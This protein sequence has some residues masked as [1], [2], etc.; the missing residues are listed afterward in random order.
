MV[1][2]KKNKLKK[3]LLIAALVALFQISNILS[4]PPTAGDFRILLLL[5]NSIYIVV[6]IA[7]CFAISFISCSSQHP[8]DRGQLF[9]N[10]LNKS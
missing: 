9:A 4:W 2:L 8:C 5:L 6:Y 7:K 10:P 3:K 1:C